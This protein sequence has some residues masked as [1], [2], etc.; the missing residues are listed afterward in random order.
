MYGFFF[1]SSR[2]RHTRCSRDWS[3]D[4]CSSDLIPTVAS[5]LPRWTKTQLKAIPE[6]AKLAEIHVP[7]GSI[8]PLVTAL[9]LP[10]LALAPLSHRLPFAFVG[11]TI[12]LLGIFRW[13]FEPFEA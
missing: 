3:S 4:V 11:A 13:A 7:G 6:G 9:G 10:V 12:I 1:F 8:W 5:R 2:R